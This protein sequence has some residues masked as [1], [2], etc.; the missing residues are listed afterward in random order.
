MRLRCPGKCCILIHQ[1]FVLNY[2]VTIA[3]ELF[4][5][6]YTILKYRELLNIQYFRIVYC[7]QFYETILK[8]RVTIIRQIGN[9]L[10]KF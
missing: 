10:C 1:G 6:P 2:R 3:A 7:A 9:H 8:H 5:C 4:Y